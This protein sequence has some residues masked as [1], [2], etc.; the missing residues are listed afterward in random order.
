[1]KYFFKG[2]SL[3]LLLYFAN[4]LCCHIFNDYG[5]AIINISAIVFFIITTAFL[6]SKNIQQLLICGFVGLFTM[7]FAEI[8]TLTNLDLFFGLEWLQI[9]ISG[10]YGSMT[11]LVVSM[12]LTIKKIKLSDLLLRR[13][14]TMTNELS[15]NL[16]IKLLL[17]ALISAFG[18][19]YLLMPENAGISVPIFILLQIICLWFILPSRKCLLFFVP[20]TIM[21]LNSFWSAN[22]IWTLPNF[23]ISLIIFSCMFFDY[24]LKS[25]SLQYFRDITIKIV[26]PISYF[27]LPFKWLLELNN[28][29]APVVKRIALALV[30]ALPCALLL[31]IVLSSADMVFSVKTEIFLNEIFEYINFHTIFIGICGIAVGLYLF[32]VIC[33]VHASSDKPR[34]IKDSHIKGDLIIIN[35]LLFVILFVYTLFVIIQFKYLFAGSVLP[36]GLTYTEYARKGFF[37]LLALTGINIA[38]ILSVIKLTK[39][40]KG[41]WNTFTKILCHYL[42]AV[43]IILLVSSFYRMWLYTNDDGLTRLR[44]FVM[45]FLLFEAIGLIITFFYI[46]KQKINITLIYICLAL[47]YY[48]ILNII[49]TDNII[50]KNQIKK[51]LSGEREDISYVFTLSA[52]AAPAMELLYNNTQDEE[53]KNKVKEF[54]EKETFSD[55]PKR[56][57]RYN[58]AT[59]KALVI[60]KNVNK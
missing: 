26:A 4:K 40:Y 57:Q 45:G 38:I 52:D 53:L 56:W 3:G 29:K 54:L 25:D 44:F 18:F 12:L 19:S 9:Y 17:Y 48:T 24:D 33:C 39:C 8:L 46:A 11:A 59:E 5:S 51:Y 2:I 36:E 37:E 32:G 22:N 16:K 47:I 30:I 35:I 58:I 21:A 7:F 20:I 50:A 1:M 41:K 55:I 23:L 43:T 31:I 34:K 6:V 42:C 13:C 15:K 28:E 10:F 49:P 27:A 14:K 60:L